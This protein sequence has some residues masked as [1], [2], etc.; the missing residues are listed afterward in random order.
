M[1]LKLV[2]GKRLFLAFY[3]QFHDIDVRQNSSLLIL[4]HLSNYLGWKKA[5]PVAFIQ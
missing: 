3:K 2:C 1:L 4:T 5:S